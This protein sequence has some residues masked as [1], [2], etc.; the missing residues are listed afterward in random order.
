MSPRIFRI[1]IALSGILGAAALVAYFAAPWT[2]MPL[3]LSTASAAEVQ[4]F[5]TQYHGTLLWDTWLQ[6]VGSLLSIIFP[7]GLVH[8]LWSN[9]YIFWPRCR[10]LTA[11]K[12]LAIIGQ[13]DT[14]LSPINMT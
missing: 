7:I 6:A 5:G 14:S 11:G 2:W 10:Y 8:R 4:A 9:F 1:L 13:I 3:P 12:N